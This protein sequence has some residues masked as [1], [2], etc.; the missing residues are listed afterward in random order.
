MK[1]SVITINFN[2]LKGLQ[3]TIN[4]IVIQSFK[5]FEYIIIDGG[6]SDGSTGLIKQFS[7][8]ITYWVSEPDNGIFHAMNK[9]IDKARGEY[10]LFMNSGDY[11]IHENILD[12]AFSFGFTEDYVFGNA[13]LTKNDEVLIAD[14]ITPVVDPSLY[15]MLFQSMPQPASFIKRKLFDGNGKF[16]ESLK[17]TGDWKFTVREIILNNCSVRHL[18]LTICNYDNTGVSSVNKKQCE[19]EKKMVLQE[20]LPPRVMAD[21]E[22]WSR[23]RLDNYR[24]DWLQ[25]HKFF[26]KLFVLIFKTGRK[27][28]KNGLIKAK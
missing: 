15:D 12:E 2:N 11:L 18:P 9:G 14:Y 1:L 26:Y 28:E 13:N 5:D 10:I 7:E 24:L 20:L 3:N 19:L 8:K 25:Q 23:N 16:D 27:M 4:S 21:Y 6:S 22:K 17:I